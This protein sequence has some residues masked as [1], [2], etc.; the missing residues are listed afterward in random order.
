M[1]V[2]V[3]LLLLFLF[4]SPFLYSFLIHYERDSIV[5]KAAQ[6]YV[7]GLIY[8]SNLSRVKEQISLDEYIG[9]LALSL[10]DSHPLRQYWIS[11]MV[12][13]SYIASKFEEIYSEVVS[14]YLSWQVYSDEATSLLEHEIFSF[15]N[16]YWVV[17]RGSKDKLKLCKEYVSYLD[18][19]QSLCRN[20]TF[21]NLSWQ[22]LFSIYHA[23][24]WLGFNVDNE[25]FLLAFNKAYFEGYISRYLSPDGSVAPPSILNED[26]RVSYTIRALMLASLLPE[27]VL[28]DYLS[29]SQWL[30]RSVWYVLL[31]QRPNGSFGYEGGGGIPYFE[32][33]GND[34]ITDTA[35]MV[36]VMLRLGGKYTSH[37][38]KAV[39]YLISMQKGDGSW[40]FLLYS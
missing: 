21:G 40:P 35:I 38:E 37:L 39:K 2:A 17:F 33:P 10:P 29:R 24:R 8:L 25:D 32:C 27:E 22:M 9:M 16:E 15:I 4:L 1:W 11:V 18:S 6:S 3:T 19:L 13:D 12:N 28:H 5:D 14:S 7:R 36:H 30:N 31:H 26:R 34:P 23:R 20:E